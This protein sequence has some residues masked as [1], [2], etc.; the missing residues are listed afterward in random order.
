MKKVLVLLMIMIVTITFSSCVR[1]DNNI[2]KYADDVE[3]Y[4]AGLFMPDLEDIGDYKEISYFSRKDESIFP[5]YSLQLIAKYDEK[6]FLQE[7][8]RLESAYTYL[9]QPQKDEWYDDY[10]MP[11]TTFSYAS[12]DF[13]VAQ[14]EDTAYPKK[15]GMVGVS[16]EKCEIVYLWVYDPDLDYI[17]EANEDRNK[18]MIEYIELHFSLK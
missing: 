5:Q 18:K 17:C 4:Y 10:T 14:L 1:T 2:E 8:E 11:V 12:F 13:R 16:D 15:F 6:I 3:N 7:K 9:D